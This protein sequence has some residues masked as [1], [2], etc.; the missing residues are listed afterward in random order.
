MRG[1][2]LVVMLAAPALAA[3]DVGY[4]DRLIRWALA[5]HAREVEPSPEGK[6]VEEV[7]I[8]SEDVFAPSDPWPTALNA[9]HW[10]TKENVIRRE[11]LLAPGDEWSPARVMETER[12]LRRLYIVAVV[13]V[14]PVKGREGGV[15]VLVVT[16]DR[17]SLRLN[18]EFTLIGPL[19]QYLRLQPTEMNFLGLNQ[20]L[21]LDVILRLDTL[22]LGQSFVE[23]RL[24][25]TRLYLGEAAALVVNRQ[26]GKVEGSAAALSFG[27][28]LI[29]LDQTWGFLLEGHWNVR[30]RRVFR[31]AS[32]WLL[33]Y[34][35]DAGP[36]TV[37][38]VYDVREGAVEASAIRSFGREVKLDTTAAL[39]GYSRWY[40]PPA[41]S[42]L[43]EEQAAWFRAGYLP[44]T[45]DA[46]Y[47]SAFAR[48]FTADFRVLR[49]MDTFELSEDYQ[50]GPL[51]QA[52]VRYAFPALSQSHFVELGAA[53]RWRAYLRDDLFTVSLAGQTRLRPGLPAANNRVA[54]E[55][56]NYSPPLYGGRLV[57]RVMF[58]VKTDDLDNRR[59][60]LGGSNGLRGAFPEQL[61]GKNVLLANVEY[62]ARPF[63]L[64]TNW[65]GLVFFYDVGS[66]FNDAPALTHS[67]GVGLRLLL[68]Q[69]NQEAIR[70]DLGVVIG[71]PAPGLDRLNASYGQVTDLRPSF[72]DQPL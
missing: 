61:T 43:S 36:P 62:R 6:R 64:A 29:T 14:V 27:R 19:L 26:T 13:K 49:N 28:P 52:G 4:E 41:A 5:E 37:P 70:I 46:T 60:L 15:G 33:P 7:L 2:A 10:K 59:L 53:V 30:R 16:K 69:F 17:W 32:V 3:E 12:N 23:R 45:E 8:A 48:A 25:G 55:V 21:S 1:L 9:F 11:V 24:G 44:R 58:D 51:V 20:R 18:S 66:A 63:E 35:D 71:G 40:G 56:V 42:A 68:P 67:V 38:F 50:L 47:V 22:Q 72:L 39:G 31:G 65:V 57:T 54:L 34:P